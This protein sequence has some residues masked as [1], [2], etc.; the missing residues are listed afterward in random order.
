VLAIDR[1][2][3]AGHKADGAVEPIPVARYY[4]SRRLA[5]SEVDNMYSEL[6]LL[7]LKLD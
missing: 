2:L 1:R 4:K 7:D 3:L 6:L 5:P